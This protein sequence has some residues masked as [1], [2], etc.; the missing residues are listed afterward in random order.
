MIPEPLEFDGNDLNN[1]L[2]KD[3]ALKLDI[4]EEKSAPN[5]FG[6]Y[7]DTYWQKKAWQRKAALLLFV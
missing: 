7:L 6:I 1:F 2:Q 5:Q 3:P 4:L